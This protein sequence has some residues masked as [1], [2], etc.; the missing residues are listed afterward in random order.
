MK[1]NKKMKQKELKWEGTMGWVI[2]LW[3]L[4]L[5][6]V[7]ESSRFL[8]EGVKGDWSPK[9]RAFTKESQLTV[10]ALEWNFFN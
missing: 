4:V 6:M 1:S 5:A 3:T 2:I 7:T 10:A 8:N 9:L